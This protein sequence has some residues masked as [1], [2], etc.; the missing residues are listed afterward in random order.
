MSLCRLIRQV[1]SP[2]ESYPVK[3]Q[4]ERAQKRGA[5]RAHR[6]EE[7]ADA[8]AE[9]IQQAYKA[10]YDAGYAACKEAVLAEVTSTVKSFTSMV[11]DLGC[12]RQRLI[13]ESEKAV[14]KISCEIAK[15]IVGKIAEIREE[16]VVE[17]VKNAL[18]HLADKQKV[19]I[20][21]NPKDYEVLKEHESEW[22]AAAGG[23]GA[24]RVKDDSRIKRGG[25]LIEGES[26]SVEAQLDRQVEVIGRALME[27]TR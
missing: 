23:T 27:A 21:V 20:M 10:G 4:D 6:D 16:M 8:E 15:R 7:T 1:P 17:I 26:G 22:L 13:K 9:R 24:V 12:Q 11:D 5:C 25:C 3:S 19:T 18:N 14:V 2:K